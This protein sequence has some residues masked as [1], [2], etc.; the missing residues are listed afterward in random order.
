MKIPIRGRCICGDVEYEAS[1]V[2]V[3]SAVCH[4]R[5]CRRATGGANFP[6]LAVVGDGFKLSGAVNAFETIA[7]S[8]NRVNRY[9]C[10]R[11]G[12][13][14][15]ARS[16]GMVGITQIAAA[17]LDDPSEFSPQMHVFA[18]SAPAWDVLSPGAAVFD[19]MPPMPKP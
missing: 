5:D 17:T 11:C 3:V 13:T 14:L 7:E 12:S 16:T 10:A 8:G 1:A 9:F 4:C 19:G 18:R 6:A 15:F 2:P